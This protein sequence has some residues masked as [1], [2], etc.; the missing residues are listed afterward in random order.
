VSATS[1]FRESSVS[2]RLVS[3]RRISVVA[4]APVSI[5]LQAT[6]VDATLDMKASFA[7]GK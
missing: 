7:R 6:S 1:A 2:N 5:N 4:M 3:A